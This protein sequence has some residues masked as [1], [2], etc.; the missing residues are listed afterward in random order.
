MLPGVIATEAMYPDEVTG[1]WRVRGFTSA[2]WIIDPTNSWI[3]NRE[4]LCG[5]RSLLVSMQNQYPD[6]PFAQTA[7]E[8]VLG[9]FD[10]VQRKSGKRFQDHE[11]LQQTLDRWTGG[12]YKFR[13]CGGRN[14]FRG[15]KDGDDG[16]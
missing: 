11:D 1:D 9:L 10:E 5:V 4:S 16:E 14:G 8:R 15:R 3:G 2:D 13:Y 7:L 6:S 12:A